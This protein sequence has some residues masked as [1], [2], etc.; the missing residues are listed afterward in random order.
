MSIVVPTGTGAY[1][2]TM[3]PELAYLVVREGV[4][5]EDRVIVSGIQKARPGMQVDPEIVTSSA[6]P[7]DVDTAT[8]PTR[9]RTE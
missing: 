3:E 5:R 7:A 6:I 1:V 9:A 4:S 8:A 2:V